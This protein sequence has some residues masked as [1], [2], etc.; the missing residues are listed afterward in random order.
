MDLHHAIGEALGR[1]A[2]GTP[3][4][5]AQA[6]GHSAGGWHQ[7]QGDESIPLNVERPPKRRQEAQFQPAYVPV[8]ENE[9]AYV[10]VPGAP[11]GGEEDGEVSAARAAEKEAWALAAAAA[12]AA[13]KATKAAAAVAAR[14]AE[15]KRH[16]STQELPMRLATKAAPPIRARVPPPP[17]GAR[18]PPPIGASASAAAPSSGSASAS[19][20][21]T[22]KFIKGMG[23]PPF[24]FTPAPDDIAG[25]KLRKVLDKHNEREAKRRARR[26]EEKEKMEAEKAAEQEVAEKEGDRGSG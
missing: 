22:C 12:A 15:R 3:R 4:H 9:P 13:A 5:R 24:K 7:A 14:A 23:E 16:P 10:P 21:P 26:K 25:Q 20:R 8:P 17:I 19:P 2:F 18:P 11:P 1:A 6:Q